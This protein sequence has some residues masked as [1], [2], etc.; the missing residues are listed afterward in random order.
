MPVIGKIVFYFPHLK[1]SLGKTPTF[2][3][4][5]DDVLIIPAEPVSKHNIQT[6]AQCA[7]LRIRRTTTRLFVFPSSMAFSQLANWPVR[8]YIIGLPVPF[9]AKINPCS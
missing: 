2:S 9:D 7:G 8:A 6:L 3:A 4:L 5:Y 1:N